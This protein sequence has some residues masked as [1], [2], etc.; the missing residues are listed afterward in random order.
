MNGNKHLMHIGA[1]ELEKRAAECLRVAVSNQIPIADLINPEKC[2]VK[3]LPYLAWAFSVDQWDENWHETQ[4]RLAIKQSFL[5]HK[6]KGTITALKRVVES[7]GYF[8]SLK[9]WF[10]TRPQGVPGTFGFVFKVTETGIDEAIYD[11]LIRL[12][13]DVKPV[14]RHLTYLGIAIDSEGN[15]QS[16]TATTE[17]EIITTYALPDGYFGVLS[18][19]YSGEIITT[20]QKGIL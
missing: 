8:L 2:P 20:Y 5:V 9:E 12:I 3:L 1:T 19:I 10:S 11:E 18:A 7:L 6:Q 4:K 14:S 15:S 13:E 17:G 16:F